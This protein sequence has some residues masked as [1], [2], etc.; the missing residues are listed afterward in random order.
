[1][2]PSVR[3]DRLTGATRIAPTALSSP[4]VIQDD[5]LSPECPFHR[6][7]ITSED[8]WEAWAEKKGRLS[9]MSVLGRMTCPLMVVVTMEDGAIIILVSDSATG[10]TFQGHENPSGR[11]AAP[12]RVVGLSGCVYGSKRRWG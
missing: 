9:T 10:L 4:E 3:P 5:Q 7:R 6:P 2:E 1:M 8:F 11:V 12:M